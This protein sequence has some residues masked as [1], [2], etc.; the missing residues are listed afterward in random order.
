MALQQF[1]RG[2]GAFRHSSLYPA[3]VNGVL[4]LAIVAL[5][6]GRGNAEHKFMPRKHLL[7]GT[8]ALSIQLSAP[9]V[10]Y[11]GV[12]YSG[13]STV[14]GGVAP[15]KFS[16]DGSLPNGL[17]L[18]ATTGAISG[19]S[20]VVSTKTFKVIVTD[21]LGSQSYAPGRISVVYSSGGSG[22]TVSL[23]PTG[24][25][26]SAGQTQQ[27]SAT[28]SGTTNTAVSWSASAGTIST[29]GLF[30]APSVTSNTSVTVTATSAADTTKKASATVSV[31]TGT[32][33]AVTV[34]PTTANVVSGGTKQFGASVTGT[35]NTAVNW[36]TSAGSISSGGMFTAPTVS[37]N[38]NVTVT[39]T[40]LAD[41]TKK[42]SA[43]V[44]VTPSPT[45]VSITTSY[46][47]GAQVS[48]AYSYALQATGGTSPY[49]WVLASGSLPQGFSL[50]STGQLAGST[51]QTGQFSFVAKVTDTNNNSASQSFAF[52][53][54]TPVSS[55]GGNS[56]GPAQ[57]P[58]IFMQ[59]ALANTPA[60]G[61]VTLVP[62]GGSVQNAI[63]AANCGDTIQLAAGAVFTGIVTFPAK[64]CDDLHWIIVRTSAPDTA[65]PPEGSRML[66]C[67]G[68]VSSLPARPS[69]SCPG[70][71]TNVLATLLDPV[72]SNGNSGPIVL[73]SGANHYRFIGL[74]ITRTTGG[75]D[76]RLIGTQ[77]TADHII[78]DRVWL[79]GT[80]NDET[81]TAFGMNGMSYSALIDSYTSDMHCTSVV[82]V[83]TDAKVVG[84]GTSSTQDGPYKITNN[85]LEASGENIL[86]GGGGAAYT[87]ADIEIRGN[88][89]YKP[90][91]W[92][93]GQ[94]GFVG[95]ASGYPFI[96]KNHL[97]LKNA[98]RVLV[99][100]NIFEYV[101]GGYSQVGFSILLTPKNQATQTGNVCPICAVMDVT[102]RYNK[103]SHVGT[104]IA[105]ADSGSD[106][107]GVA[108]AGERY[109]IHDITVDDISASKYNGSGGLFQV[110]SGWP[111]NP[112]NN[113]SISHVTAFPD[114]I[115]HFLSLGND[116]N[117]PPM[118]AFAMTNSILG[119]VKYPVW[120]TGG[121]SNCAIANVPLTSL[122]ACFPLGYTFK[123]NA[124]IGGTQGNY[125]LSQWP[126]SNFF[127]LDA[128][129]VQFVNFNGGNGGDYH[130]QSSSP[131][132]NAGTDGKDLGADVDAILAATANAY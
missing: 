30:T 123:A 92:K 88:H 40:S 7:T 37:A 11:V 70:G 102:I 91:I 45:S 59:T 32:T 55:G 4:I 64:P 57:L 24:A 128:T 19:K 109:S 87:P 124:I 39:A 50:S 16:L 44:F 125:L 75:P 54:S 23:N 1:G 17:A 73:A 111:T 79:R 103:I 127:P 95:G 8:S 106:N 119:Q 35:S 5:A 52:S 46:V 61:A 130:L 34:S 56:D 98:Q 107:G 15:Y 96:V 105:L 85:F 12:A 69:F 81:A 48:T 43:A 47:P 93:L 58:R 80:P 74:D 31:T 129:S 118:Y 101:W 97:E 84:G 114:P 83:C 100:G 68:G 13:S 26:L 78:A 49:Q 2:N 86:F 121:L 27:F 99:E 120:S 110:F 89:F 126:S 112:L 21:A 94:T 117:L 29:G 72:P 42:S 65:L 28:V 10:A 36:T 60:P 9:A 108:L 66:P 90:L 82:G 51:T 67:Y 53:V 76:F 20:W 131:Y 77:G 3:I 41:S 33:I 63:N 132:K 38:T 6:A 116:V 104:G 71:V 22:I 62:P 14:M 115:S 122:T 113:I 18:N 25:T